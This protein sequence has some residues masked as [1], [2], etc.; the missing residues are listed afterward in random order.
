MSKDNHRYHKKQKYE[1]I[2]RLDFIN[3]KRCNDPVGYFWELKSSKFLNL[4]L[5]ICFFLIILEKYIFFILSKNIL[6]CRKNKLFLMNSRKFIMY[7]LILW[8][9]SQW[10]FWRDIFNTEHW[11]EF[12]FYS[13]AN[14]E[15][16]FKTTS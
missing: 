4:V 6:S 8:V 16:F 1:S 11:K 15:V 14:P 9:S 13:Q 5:K 12:H 7:H 2:F 3:W 10:N